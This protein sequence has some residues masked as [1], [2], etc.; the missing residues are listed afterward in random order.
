ME[1][2]RMA[3]RSKEEEHED[4]IMDPVDYGKKSLKHY[5]LRDDS[6]LTDLF[7]GLFRSTL[8]CLN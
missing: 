1:S 2:K 7:M 3:E 8:K 4:S 6:H 5:L